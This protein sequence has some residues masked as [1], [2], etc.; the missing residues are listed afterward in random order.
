MIYIAFI[1]EK[2]GTVH[3]TNLTWQILCWNPTLVTFRCSAALPPA[4]KPKVLARARPGLGLPATDAGLLVLPA[5]TMTWHERRPRA[6]DV[7]MYQHCVCVCVL[8]GLLRRSTWSDSWLVFREK[9]LSTK[10][11]LGLCSENCTPKLKR[12]YLC[13]HHGYF[14]NLYFLKL[15]FLFCS[16]VYISVYMLLGKS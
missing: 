1:E 10:H 14:N 9:R 13:N 5:G 16:D 2:R 8:E 3:L 7:N 11:F 4:K 12:M 15:F 6:G